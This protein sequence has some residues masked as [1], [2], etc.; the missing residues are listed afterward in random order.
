MC[1][2]AALFSSSQAVKREPLAKA[3]ASLKHRGPDNQSVWID[4]RGVAGLAHARLSLLDLSHN[5]HQPLTSTDGT[6]K[7]IHNGEFYDFERLKREL[8]TKGHT[9]RTKS[10]SEIL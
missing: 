8:E 10:D 9:F 5:G 4:E 1:G 2:F 7:V 6:L 3:A